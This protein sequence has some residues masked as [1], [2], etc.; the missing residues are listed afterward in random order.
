VEVGVL[1]GKE[2]LECGRC[3]LASFIGC[4]RVDMI[5]GARS[6]GSVFFAPAACDMQLSLFYVQII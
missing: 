2:A 6:H 4:Y 1:D 3:R 5:R